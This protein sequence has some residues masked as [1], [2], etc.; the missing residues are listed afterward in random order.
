MQITNPADILAALVRCPSV[1]PAEAGTLDVVEAVT[2]RMG[3]ATKRPVFSAPDTP[4]VEN[5]YSRLGSSGPVLMFAGHTDVV[6]PGEE[7]A[8]SHP[9]FS[10]AIQGEKLFGRGAVDM[11]GGIAAFLAALAR[12][13]E[14]SGPPSGS[15]ALAITCDEE[16]PSINGTEKLLDWAVG[17]GERWDAAIVGEPTNPE[18]V[19]DAIKIGRRGSVSGKVKVTG[20]QGHSAYPHLADNPVDGLLDLASG[21]LAPSIDE[22]SDH[23]EPTRLVITSVDVGNPA[24]N[25]IPQTARLSFNIRFNEL[26]NGDTICR[27]VKRRLDSAAQH[28]RLRR[29][30]DKPVSYEIEW[31]GRISPVFITR[32][33]K[34]IDDFSRAVE[35]VAGKKPEL[36][37]GGGTSDARFIKDHC[38]VIEFGLV[39]KTMHQIDEHV[40]LSDLESL[41]AI[42]QEFLAQWFDWR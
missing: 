30:V 15:V 18:Q 32:E 13:F 2:G 36:S 26:W 5:L 24:T 1:T 29:G 40:A 3:F 21:L 27:E 28:G 14:K 9:P 10:A 42:Y 7:T 41:T 20:R 23:F 8:W 33:E 34:L 25:V 37:T 6:P 31:V 35:T 38:P 11:K 39:G 12:Q 16:G 17:H 19:G 4:D 22:G